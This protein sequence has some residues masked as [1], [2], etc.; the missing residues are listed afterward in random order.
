MASSTRGCDPQRQRLS[1]IRLTISS[2]EGRAF[3][4]SRAYALRIIPGVQK[5]HWKAWCLANASWMGCRRPFRSNPSMVSTRLPATS[6]MGVEQDRTAWSSTS[7]VQAPHSP[8]PQPNLAPVSPRS[9]RK[10]HS[11]MRSSSTEM[12]VALPL[13]VKEMGRSMGHLRIQ[14][15]RP[16]KHPIGISPGVL[17]QAARS[18][19]R[20]LGAVYL[21]APRAHR[22]P[23][24]MCRT[25]SGL[26][27]IS[28]LWP[29]AV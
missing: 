19:D 23:P 1:S 8:S 9:L 22:T 25:R 13:R 4:A 27:Y 2:R 28:F 20:R 24:R 16:T 21:A 7:T 3:S 5:P 6:P 29:R 11:S 14:N 17:E 12:R 18:W 10:T 26:E 15:N